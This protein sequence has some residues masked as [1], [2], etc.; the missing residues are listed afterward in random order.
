MGRVLHAALL[1]LAM[2]V[3]A[4]AEPV[5]GAILGV[6]SWYGSLSVVGQLAVQIGV[7]LALSA[8]SY[9]LQYLLSGGGRRQQEAQQ[10]APGVQIPERDGLLEGSRLYGTHV[11][12]GGVFF[13]KTIA[14]SGSAKPNVYVYGLA[15][16][17]GE[18]DSLVSVIINGIECQIDSSGNPI[19]APWYN[20]SGNFLKASFRPGTS[21][22]A[23]DSIIAARWPTPPAD[24]LPDD[25]A[26]LSKWPE[27][28]QRGVCTVVLEMKFGA[29]ADQHTELW[30]S[31]G[32][33]QIAVKLKGLKI[34]DATDPNQSPSNPAG[35]KWQTNATLVQADWLTCDMGF[36]IDPAEIDW[37]SVRESALLDAEWLPTLGGS[38]QR[39]TINGRITSSE[40]NVD[41][42]AA[43]AQQ[44]RALVRKSFGTYSIRT[45]RIAEPVAT[46]HQWLL[47]GDFSYRNEPD[48]RAAINRVVTQFLPES[49]F[50]QSAETV[51]ED[52]ALIAADGQ[53]FEQRVTLRFCDSA[54][55]AQRLGFAMVKENRVG[56]TVTGVFDIAVLIAAGKPDQLLSAGDV[57][58]LELASPY[59]DVNGLYEVNSLE[60]NGDFTVTV[61]MTGTTPE[62]FTGWSTAIETVFE[63]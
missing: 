50:N 43:M 53:V 23:M 47:V 41:V 18:C 1:M 45:D 30:G 2:T 13:Q 48:T 5:T 7:G 14:D 15:L 26:R 52:P 60:V 6:A 54:P 32:I 29:N 55:T 61:A 9:G 63:D 10:D 25:A 19:T 62:I 49:R 16:S 59:G 37:A 39:G 42:L 36:A 28:R 57:I 21:T 35:W 56:R 20:A 24:F 22:Q 33:P 58:W 3:P 31:G 17:E 8:A 51:F 11:V 38:E 40:A 44:N 34:L 4:H 46:I 27:F 12:A